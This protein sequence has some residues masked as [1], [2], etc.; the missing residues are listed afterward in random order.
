MR[1]FQ[2]NFYERHYA[3]RHR[4]LEEELD[5]PLLSS[6]YTRLARRILSHLEPTSGPVR[7]LEV[8][9]GEGLLA[10]ALARA[11]NSLG[12]ELLYFGTDISL[13]AVYL[14]RSALPAP[15]AVADARRVAAA[16]RPGSLDAVVAKNLLHHLENPVAFLQQ[17]RRLLKIGGR[18]ICVEASR[19]SPQAWIFSLLAPR[20]ER[21][22]FTN[23][24]SRVRQALRGADLEVLS[25]EV[26]SILPF[27]LLLAVRF[28]V[29]RRL[30]DSGDPQG[31]R[32]LA[33]RVD[34][35][36][37]TLTAA[38]PGLASYRIWVAERK[39]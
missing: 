7:V 23:S 31:R 17:A 39:A 12:R 32:A 11:A 10:S 37:E 1:N 29:F 4:V 24:R 9:C 38:L 6:F 33:H 25:E 13:S 16:F 2:R 35:L 5:H 22:F 34:A 14:A 8:G 21:Y 27:E 19:G 36:D 28:G 15:Y 20:R 3:A 18:V 26:F 30:L